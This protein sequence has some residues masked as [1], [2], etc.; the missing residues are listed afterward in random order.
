[1]KKTRFMVLIFGMIIAFWSV[2][3]LCVR[4]L[5]FSYKL[6][7]FK[8]TIPLDKVLKIDELLIASAILAIV[9]IISYII[10]SLYINKYKQN[11]RRI[12]LLQERT[13]TLLTESAKKER[14]ANSAKSE[15]LSKI[16]HDIRTPINGIMGM[17]RIVKDNLNSPIKIED[18]INK[19]ETAS[20]HLFSLINDVLDMSSIEKGKIK[21]NKKAI[22]LEELI[23][24]IVMML[25]YQIDIK[26]H[27][28]NVFKNIKHPI[29]ETD[30]LRLKQIIMNVLSNAIKY[31]DPNGTISFTINEGLIS[32]ERSVYRF[33]VEDNGMGMDSEMRNKI[34]D[35]FIQGRNNRKINNFEG[36]G[37]GM[38]IVKGLVEKFEGNIIIKSE[39]GSGTK[40]II[41]IPFKTRPKEEKIV[42]RN[43]EGKIENKK[44]LIVDDND[45][46]LEILD[47]TMKK[48]GMTTHCVG[49]GFS[50]VQV[51]S[52]SRDYEY[53]LVLMDI[54]MPVLDGLEATKKIRS[55]HR[56]DLKN[57]PIIGI[58]ANAYSEDEQKSIE[59]GM[60]SHIS[61]PIIEEKLLY[62]IKNLL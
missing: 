47:Y 21:L 23:E 46:N 36:T 13:N 25:S 24:E 58:T 34:F 20:Q 39:I 42:V 11:F 52:S 37:L 49:N 32:K 48:F 27:N 8:K 17:S 35:P 59:V 44:V 3:R 14:D 57:V 61:K 5:G 2:I 51:L 38:S 45:L 19:I 54:M 7:C 10:S 4:W 30:Q 53:D 1:M 9:L 62:E 22:N 31:T 43:K 28:F 18:C 56:E 40:V 50:A 55:S 12:F 26:Q 6:L 60:N 15:F 16:S 33:I 29:I 41:I